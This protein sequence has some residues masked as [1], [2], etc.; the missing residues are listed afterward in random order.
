[1]TLH[2]FSGEVPSQA[3]RGLEWLVRLRWWASATILFFSVFAS[4]VYSVAIPWVLICAVI[5]LVAATNAWLHFHKP[6]QASAIHRWLV[7]LIFV[8]V[9]LL[10]V[11]LY[12]TGGA[13][14]PFTV[15]YVL[16]I[17]LAVMLLNAKYAW[18]MV[19]LCGAGF[20][21]LFFSN[22]MLIGPTGEAVCD[23]LDFHLQGM[24]AATVVTGAGVVYFV[25]HLSRSL[26]QLR[27]VAAQARGL[28]EKER[29]FSSILA[30]AAGV[31]HELATPLGTIAIASRELEISSETT[32]C[33]AE[34]CQDVKLIRKEV[35]KCAQI[36]ARMGGAVN[37]AP[38]QASPPV[39][40]HEI[41]PLLA[42]YLPPEI[43]AG[44]QW[45]QPGTFPQSALLSSGDLL[46]ILG[47][48]VRNAWESTGGNLPV[49]VSMRPAKGNVAVF[50]VTDN[51]PGMKPEIL[52]R[53]GEPFFTTKTNQR[54]GMGLG[55]FLAKSLTERRGGNILVESAPG[56]G[57][58]ITIELPF[59]SGETE[60]Q[61]SHPSDSA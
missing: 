39:P 4:V 49:S 11:L 26:A 2:L 20:G 22:H 35:D 8:D 21:L 37:S 44:I 18:F 29:H 7:G 58:C 19:G 3:L 42:S 34:C 27:E 6:G 31:A 24:F 33:N 36:L 59:C 51:G 17:T 50:T 53:L 5:A 14:N 47:N 54:A 10:T 15:L 16:H 56:S 25:A 48:V 57:T 13:H 30:M 1:M 12:Y 32:G 52:Q 23:D 61:K 40:M 38:D 60:S 41:Q 46:I 9:I 43:A 45:Q 55:F 28:A